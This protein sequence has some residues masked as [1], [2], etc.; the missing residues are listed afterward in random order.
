MF[1]DFDD[2]YNIF[3]KGVFKNALLNMLKNIEFLTKKQTEL[4]LALKLSN[5]KRGFMIKG[6]L[7][8]KKEKDLKETNEKIKN[9]GSRD[10]SQN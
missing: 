4:P 5:Y 7:D 2:F 3:S 10:T 8:F 1:L 9:I 6:L